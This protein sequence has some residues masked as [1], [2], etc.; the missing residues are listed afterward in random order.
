LAEAE[1]ALVRIEDLKVHFPIRRGAILP[2]T[3]GHVRAVDG[4][5]IVLR[6]GETLGLVGE[7]GCGKSTLGRAL[8][9]IH[10]PS[11][12]RILF[13]GADITGLAGRELRHLARRVQMIFQD[14]YS[15][16]DPRMRIGDIIAEPLEVHGIGRRADRR[17]RVAELLEIVGLLP[18]FADLYPHQLSG[19][20]RQRVG[21][22]RAIALNLDFIVCD[23]AVSALDVSIQAQIVNLLQEL[24]QRLGLT[25]L[26]IAHDLAVV[27][28]ISQRIV[29]MYLGRVMES[30]AADAMVREPLHP[31]TRLPMASVPLPDPASDRERRARRAP[32]TGELPSPANPPNGC[33]FATRCP[34]ARDV[35]RRF[36]IEC[37]E[38]EP[39]LAEVQPGRNA[40]CHLY[41]PCRPPAT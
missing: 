5:S 18:R 20:Q 2:R 9:R 28:H 35:R 33:R 8:L 14:A 29:V 37:G 4:V 6:R 15:S 36:G 7:S 10:D 16:V 22:A 25:Y 13:D 1:E 26:F 30:G 23:E 3:V 32:A 38:V 34:A 21:I 41:A 19:G 24:Q 27:R 12:G 40:A 31:Y 39:R 17:R 11:A